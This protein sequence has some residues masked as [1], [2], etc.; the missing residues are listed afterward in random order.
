MP[1][2][3]ARK[4]QLPNPEIL[5]LTGQHLMEAPTDEVTSSYALLY[6]DFL[7]LLNLCL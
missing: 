3:N 4:R 1:V 2:D 5:P 7:T 6:V